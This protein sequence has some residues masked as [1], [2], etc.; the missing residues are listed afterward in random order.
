MAGKDESVFT[1]AG[2]DEFVFIKAGKDE[3]VFTKAGKDESVFTKAGKDN[4][5]ALNFELSSLYTS[6]KQCDWLGM[7]YNLAC[8]RAPSTPSV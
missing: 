4:L 1:K 8:S 7:T 2:K 6:S 3:S 5:H